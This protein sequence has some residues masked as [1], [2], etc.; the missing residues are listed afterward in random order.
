M[1]SRGQ[2]FFQEAERLWKAEEGKASLPNIQGVILMGCLYVSCLDK[3][4]EAPSLTRRSLNCQ[5]KSRASWLMV[6]Q[7]VE[8]AQDFGMFRDPRTDRKETQ[9]SAELHKV[10]VV[11]AWGIFI[12]NSYDALCRPS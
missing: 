4:P 5:G 6:R 9:G 10:S 3:A 12:L 7:A 2:H 1:D 8:L 11:T